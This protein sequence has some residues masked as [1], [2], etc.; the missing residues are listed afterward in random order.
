M[1]A[2]DESTITAADDVLALAGDALL[3]RSRL[4]T[5]Y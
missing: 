1:R 5:N 3:G 2:R 4:K